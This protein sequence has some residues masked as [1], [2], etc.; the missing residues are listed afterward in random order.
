MYKTGIRGFLSGRIAANVAGPIKVQPTF[1][2]KQFAPE[3]ATR[4]KVKSLRRKE[5]RLKRQI[6]RDV[7]NVK[8]HSLKN[9]QFKVD[10]VLGDKENAFVKRI[11]TE[12]SEPTALALGYQRE[13]LEKLLYGAEKASLDRHSGNSILRQSTLAVEER[14]KR[15]VL[16]ILNIKNTNASDKKTLAVRLAREEFQ[17]KE[18][19]T[20][21]PEVQAAVLTVRIHLGMDHV[22]ENHK[23]K[24][25][26]Q[27]VREMVQ[28][29]QKILKYLKLDNPEQ[30]YHTIAKLG[31]TDD[32]ITREFNMGRQ[33]LQDYRVWG[34][35][36]L[37]KLLDKQKMKEQQVQ[38]L[39]KRVV[40]Y[41][42]LARKNWEQMQKK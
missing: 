26:I 17:R 41:N 25:H 19:D 23:D 7:N 20:G 16:T 33:Y 2:A 30:Y 31:L 28:Q 40:S 18:G 6:I 13:E 37:V 24:V 42:Q 1:A 5:D 11:R 3:N 32:V 35:K 21:S 29:R 10:P 27:N 36:V 9:V 34:D 14:K 4:S 8:K 15:A 12:L 38:E 22:R 39:Q